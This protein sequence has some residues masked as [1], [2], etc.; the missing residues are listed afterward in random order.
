[1]AR[2]NVNVVLG[3]DDIGRTMRVKVFDVTDLQF[4]K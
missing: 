1:M 3:G 4:E 2:V